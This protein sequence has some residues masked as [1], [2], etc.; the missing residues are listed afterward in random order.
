M[1][2]VMQPVTDPEEI[3]RAQ[4]RRRRF[5]RNR[6]WLQA[7]AEEVYARHRGRCISVAGEELFVA[8]TPEEAMRLG[9]A[10]HPDDDGSFVQYIPRERFTRIYAHRR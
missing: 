4:A 7:R 2:V 10:A 3:A 8:D 9:R 5:D 1:R 6:A